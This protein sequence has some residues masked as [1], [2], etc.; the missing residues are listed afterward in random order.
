MP[1]RQAVRLGQALQ[2]RAAQAMAQLAQ[3]RAEQVTL[4][5]GVQRRA[6][7]LQVSLRTSTL[8]AVSQPQAG[9]T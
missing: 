3:A 9:A 7:G 8:A 4:E 2:Q 5:L 1:L 6:E